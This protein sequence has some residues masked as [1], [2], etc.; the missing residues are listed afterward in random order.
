MLSTKQISAY[1]DDGFVLL[2]N[3]LSS[4]QVS[5]MWSEIESIL[6]RARHLTENDENFDL[7]DSHSSDRPRVRRIKKPHVQSR[8]F[9]DLVR[10]PAV[11]EPIQQL[12]G[13]N[14]RLQNSKLNLK[15]AGYG[16]PVE[17]HQDW[18]FYPHTNDDVLAIGIMV[19]DVDETNGPLM[20][21]P[22]SHQKQ[23]YDH[24]ADGVFC[25]AIDPERAGLDLT[26]AVNLMGPAGSMSIHHA[27]LV[28]G[29]APNRSDRDRGLL[30]YEIAA[31]D[32]WPLEG[33]VSPRFGS[34]KEFNGRMLCGEPTIEPRLERVPVR[35]PQ[36]AAD[37]SS[38][39]QAQKLL[40]NKYFA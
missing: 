7:D 22:G 23:V 10:Q 14:L 16:A 1:R 15:S 4:E 33:I 39:Y 20:V 11:I 2:E 6:N 26:R 19:H 18:A 30:L 21:M 32:A 17:W 8:F 25:G 29:S 38:I 34:L 37:V 28:H 13:P 40:K 36:P 31:A 24:H 3:V 12:I 35:M 5:Q 27:R 9:W